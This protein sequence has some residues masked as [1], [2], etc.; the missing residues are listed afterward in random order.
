M[1][2]VPGLRYI[3]AKGSTMFNLQCQESR[4]WRKSQQNHP[5]DHAKTQSTSSYKTETVSKS[6]RVTN[7]NIQAGGN[8]QNHWNQSQYCSDKQHLHGTNPPQLDISVEISSNVHYSGTLYDYPGKNYQHPGSKYMHPI[9]R[10]KPCTPPV[11]VGYHSFDGTY[12]STN[13]YYQPD[14]ANHPTLANNDSFSSYGGQ[15]QVMNSQHMDTGNQ[16]VA[17]GTGNPGLPT[18][19]NQYPRSNSHL[20]HTSYT[21][22]SPRA[23]EMQ[24]AEPNLSAYQPSQAAQSTHV[25]PYGFPCQCVMCIRRFFDDHSYYQEHQSTMRNSQTYWD[26]AYQSNITEEGDS[27]PNWELP[28]INN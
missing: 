24:H 6:K 8:V 27:L 12:H 17:G 14:T 26:N 22:H 2:E 13:E 18:M 20:E 19:S 16:Y 3:Y 11:E 9:P 10:P 21:N 15:S 23:P 1:V 5:K 25:H 4:I 28:L 7:S